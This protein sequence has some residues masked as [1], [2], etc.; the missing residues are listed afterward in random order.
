MIHF[1]IR[2]RHVTVDSTGS[3]DLCNGSS[4]CLLL[5][6]HNSGK[7]FFSDS[8][9]S[10]QLLPQELNSYQ[11]RLTEKCSSDPT[12][13]VTPPQIIPV[14]DYFINS[15]IR[16]TP[17]SLKGK[18][19]EGSTQALLKTRSVFESLPTVDLCSES[20]IEE[21]RQAVLPHLANLIFPLKFSFD[22]Y[23]P[24]YKSWLKTQ[25]GQEFISGLNEVVDKVF[26]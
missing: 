22:R 24:L 7:I 1:C 18:L 6:R 3:S 21:V 12:P 13:V 20:G 10:K 2:E 23:C 11:D 8:N 15:L 9:R 25:E 14:I 19:P 16:R 26:A 17:E 4:F 5:R